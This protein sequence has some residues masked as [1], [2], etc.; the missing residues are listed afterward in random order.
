MRDLARKGVSREGEGHLRSD[1]AVA[2][3]LSPPA[4]RAV[5]LIGAYR[6]TRDTMGP[7][8]RTEHA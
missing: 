1:V 7:C 3:P 6:R 4:F 2:K 5:R 8:S